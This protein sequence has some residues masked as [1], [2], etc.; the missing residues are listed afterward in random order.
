MIFYGSGCLLFV[1]DTRIR[2]FQLVRKVCDSNG[3][4]THSHLVRKRTLNYLAKLAIQGT[5]ECRFTLKRVRVHDTD[6]Q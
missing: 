6:I 4:R 2:I 3:I 1:N 5:I